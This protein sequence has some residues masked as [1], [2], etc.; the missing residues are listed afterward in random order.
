MKESLTTIDRWPIWNA[1]D[2]KSKQ[3]VKNIKFNLN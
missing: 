2:G 1:K 3:L